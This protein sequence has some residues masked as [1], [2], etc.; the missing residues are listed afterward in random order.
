MAVEM[1]WGE[2]ITVSLGIGL[3]SYEFTLDDLTLGRLN[4][5]GRLD[6]SFEGVDVTQYCQ[7][8][9]INRGRNDQTNSNFNTGVATL[10]LLN[11]DRRFDPNN[12]DSPYWNES[13]GRSGVTPRRRVTI[14]SGAET[15]F[16]GLITD[17]DIEYEPPMVGGDQENSTVTI[18]CADDFVLLANTFIPEAL[19]PVQELSGSRLEYVLDLASVNYPPL[20]RSIDTGTATLGGGAVFTIPADQQ[21]LTYCQKIAE[22]EQGYFFVAANGDLTFSDRLSSE[23][24]NVSASF[25][26]TGTDIPYTTLSIQYGQELLYNKVVCNIVDGV[27]QIVNDAASQLEYGVSTYSL[28]DLL[29]ADDS[30]ALELAE[31]LLDLY[32]L[33]EYRF[34]TISTIYNALSSVDQVTVSGLDI[35]DVLSITRTYATGSPASVTA[36][37]S[38]ESIR[39]SI[40]PNSHM[41]EYGLAVADLLY[42]FTLD[43][44]IYGILDS[45]NALT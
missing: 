39:H 5:A 29:L 25:S 16:V 4:G 21:V 13:L 28:H 14:Q 27:E 19:E 43:S 2:T 44:I 30:D 12:T 3:I 10:V 7:K 40:T 20:T 31:Y 18:T 9:E 23:F 36:E 26:D 1:A 45:T 15:L 17:I 33:P 32:K 37:Y 6:G 24:A 8:I 38:V 42:P 11:N 22:A 34:D 41:V 35:S